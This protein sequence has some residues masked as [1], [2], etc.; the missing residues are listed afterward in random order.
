MKFQTVVD[1]FN[2][3]STHDLELFIEFL[4]KLEI[5]FPGS[6]GLLS[7]DELLYLQNVQT[8]VETKLIDRGLEVPSGLSE[9]SIEEYKLIRNRYF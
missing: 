1:V 6:A 7:G 3:L 2:A 9:E 8:V 5:K 4:K